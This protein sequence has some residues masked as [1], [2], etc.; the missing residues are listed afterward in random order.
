[1]FKYIKFWLDK[2]QSSKII[3][4]GKCKQCGKCCR[5]IVFYIENKIITQED[6]FQKLKEKKPYYEHFFISGKDDDEAL[7]FTCSSIRADNKCGAYF[8]RAI[9]CRTYPWDKRSLIINGGKPLEGCGY[10]FEV[11]KKFNDYLN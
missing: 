10:N 8:W 4:K 5:N 3:Q 9:Q 2:I 7:L 11:D 6:E 1:M